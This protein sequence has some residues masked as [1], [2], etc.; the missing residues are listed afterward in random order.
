MADHYVTHKGLCAQF[1]TYFGDDDLFFV[2]LVFALQDVPGFLGCLLTKAR[3]DMKWVCRIFF[4]KIFL[5]N[6]FR[7]NE[8]TGQPLISIYM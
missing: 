4:C 1:L 5:A 8:P 2:G 6:Y 7:F 3:G